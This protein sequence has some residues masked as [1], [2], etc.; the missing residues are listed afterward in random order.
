MYLVNFHLQFLTKN[1]ASCIMYYFNSVERN[2]SIGLSSTELWGCNQI[3]LQVLQV[4]LLL[5]AYKKFSSSRL[6]FSLLTMSFST[7]GMDHPIQMI[8]IEIFVYRYLTISSFI[9]LIISMI[10]G[11]C[12]H[13]EI[14]RG[15][16]R[17]NHIGGYYPKAL[18]IPI[19]HSILFYVHY[20]GVLILYLHVKSI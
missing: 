3:P 12:W 7:L 16:P 13:S 18:Y 1:D 10:K 11:V 20:M 8:F 17:L 2:E 4:D 6:L 19:F 15:I 14:S 5:S 9:L